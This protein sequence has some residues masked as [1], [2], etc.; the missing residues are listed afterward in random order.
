MVL[1]HPVV[2]QPITTNNEKHVIKH[3]FRLDWFFLRAPAFY[4]PKRMF[5]TKRATEFSMLVPS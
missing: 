3:V 5:L 4:S 2:L 1:F